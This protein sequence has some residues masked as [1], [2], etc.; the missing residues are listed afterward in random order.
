MDFKTLIFGIVGGLGMFL[1]GL[2][3][4]SEG[5]QKYAGPSL[6]KILEVLTK[7]T[8]IGV[9]V[10]TGVTALIQSS[11][12]TTVML[13]GFVNA[14]L[15]S[16]TQAI[17]VVLGANIGTT[18]TAQIIAFKVDHY[19][20]PIVGAGCAL[21]LFVH[22]YKWKYTGQIILGFGL[23]FLGLGTMS[24]AFAP[25]KHSEAFQQLF[26]T[27]GGN[28]SLGPVIGSIL[29][30]LTG[31]LL[32][33][34]VQSSSATTG[35]TIALAASGS[36]GF[37]AAIPLVLGVNIGT[38]ITA[39]LASIGA[40]ITAKRTA[41][42]H[43]MFNV[44]GVVL[45]MLVLPAYMR[46]IEAITPHLADF[47]VTSA[48]VD[49]IAKGFSIGDHPYIARHI[50]NA[51]TLFNFINV[52]IFIPLIGLLAKVVEKIIPG[53]VEILERGV[54][55]ID[56]RMVS[57]P[58][59]ALEQ[60]V[61]EMVRMGE[62]T[63]EMIVLSTEG[64]TVNKN[65]T[66]KVL[67]R[68]EIVN[69]IQ[70]EILDFLIQ[71]DQEELSPEESRTSAVYMK[72]VSD[73]ERIGDHCENI[74]RLVQT[75]DENNLKYSPE[76]IKEIREL[77]STVLSI[78]ENSLKALATDDIA[79]AQKAIEYEGKTDVMEDQFKANQLER[80]SKQNHES[81]Y[82]GIVMIDLLSNL[83]R[84]GDHAANIARAAQKPVIHVG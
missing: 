6:R 36:I 16:L 77:K 75:K 47:T 41:W 82:G 19:A 18:I 43:T 53:E 8:F 40:N 15:I 57:T 7:N 48:D 83:E 59:L 84:I 24:S 50:A 68:E 55:H 23:L 52:I 62:L 22:K 70:R 60:T 61:K 44:L 29:G 56:K 37:S 13:I 73:I 42:A 45:I 11:S 27:F 26:I 35:I 3:M 1:F 10:G 9:L 66:P 12:A 65:N 79:C 20:L 28:S 67:E 21:Y 80:L 33:M 54:K 32:T 14:G 25:L 63:R 2:H 39:Q 34:I 64:F 5:L 30:V 78:L 17:S 72:M 58:E 4:M 46:L 38:T 51:H 76:A 71:L 49:L 69:D 31:A 74:T 81:T